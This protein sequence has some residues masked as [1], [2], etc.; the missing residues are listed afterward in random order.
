MP[1][2]CPTGLVHCE[3]LHRI[4]Y[5]ELKVLAKHYV[6]DDKHNTMS[7]MSRHR[8]RKIEPTLGRVGLH[9]IAQILPYLRTIVFGHT[10]YMRGICHAHRWRKC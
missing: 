4:M 1:S 9:V 7:M 3:G 6:D 8:S 5:T 2:P 10:V